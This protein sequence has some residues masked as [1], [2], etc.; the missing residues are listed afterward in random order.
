MT[1]HCADG[2]ELVDIGLRGRLMRVGEGFST[3]STPPMWEA[4]LAA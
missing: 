1:Y 3:I 4:D 2:K